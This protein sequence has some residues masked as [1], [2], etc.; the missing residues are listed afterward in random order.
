MTGT[1][2]VVCVVRAGKESR[3]EESVMRG[4][5]KEWCRESW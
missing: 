3:R 4:T 5:E 1:E 2:K